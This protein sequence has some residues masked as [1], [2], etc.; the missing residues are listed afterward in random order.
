[1]KWIRYGVTLSKLTENHLEMVRYW[2]NHPEVSKY[3]EFRQPITAEMQKNWF[4]AVNNSENFFFII[5]HNK[6]AVGLISTANINYHSKTG[7]CGIFVWDAAWAGSPVPVFAA[8]SMLDFVFLI[9]DLEYTN[10][11]VHKENKK[12]VAYNLSL[13][14]ELLPDTA[15]SVFRQYRLQREKYFIKAAFLRKLGKKMFGNASYLYVNP[16]EDM[17]NNIT[18]LPEQALTQLNITLATHN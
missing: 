16:H 11:K 5:E 8:L 13:G 15:G 2:R 12:A 3:M 18:K 10:I 6:N 14:Y 1:M 7:S 9:L 17:P 4:A